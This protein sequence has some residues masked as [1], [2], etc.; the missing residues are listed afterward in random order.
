MVVLTFVAPN[1]FIGATWNLVQDGEVTY[2]RVIADP[3]NDHVLLPKDMANYGIEDYVQLKFIRELGEMESVPLSQI[4][5]IT[6][7]AGKKLFIHGPF[8]SHG[9]CFSNKQKRDECIAAIEYSSEV[10]ATLDFE[11]V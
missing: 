1:L 5:K 7:E 3:R 10:A 11:S 2:Y 9:I 4:S 6:L 8:G